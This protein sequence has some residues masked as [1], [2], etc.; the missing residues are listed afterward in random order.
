[1]KDDVSVKEKLINAAIECINEKG[2][3]AVTIRGIAQEAKVNSAAIN[4]YFG[5]K[6]RL[7]NAAMKKALN[8]AMS[9]LDILGD[10]RGDYKLLLKFF[11]HNFEGMV[12]YPEITKSV[13]HQPFTSN[14]YDSNTLE[15]INGFF[16]A[17]FENIK[18]S[19]AAKDDA[20]VRFIVF[21]LFSSLIFPSI[22]PGIF[23]KFTGLDLGDQGVR[24]AYIESLLEKYFKK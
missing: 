21:Q 20:S 19:V 5:S 17:F 18:K 10:S 3:D 9:N 13:L 14:R 15:W 1:M 6:K 4:Y 11:S 16:G 12:K 22:F 7:L 8:N 23:K 24:D 2:F